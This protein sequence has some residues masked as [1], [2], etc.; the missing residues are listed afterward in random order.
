MDKV[1][2][3]K[4]IRMNIPGQEEIEFEL[5]S[6]KKLLIPLKQSFEERS[7]YTEKGLHKAEQK[8]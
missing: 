7:Q 2:A 3:C 5:D 4:G 1:I 6:K 8:L